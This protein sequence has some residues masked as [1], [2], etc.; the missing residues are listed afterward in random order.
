MRKGIQTFLTEAGEAACYALCIIE[1]AERYTDTRYD[2][3]RYL[4]RGVSGGYIYYDENNPD[5]DNNFYVSDPAGYLS[6]L[7]GV[8]WQVEKVP[9]DYPS[10]PA[11]SGLSEY[12]VE[13]WERKKTG[14]TIGHF[15]LQDWDSLHDSQTVKY[16]QIVSKR[17]FRRV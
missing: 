8:N 3:T 15:R 11:Y 12:V 6:D 14:Q 16:G 4:E 9:A 17:R 7:T 13:R 10:G 1:I 5:D 2:P